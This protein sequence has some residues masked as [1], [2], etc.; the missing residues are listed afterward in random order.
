MNNVF[1]LNTNG[2]KPQNE[3]QPEA[4]VL[5]QIN[6]TATHAGDSYSVTGAFAD[7]LQYAALAM[8]KTLSELA[9]KIRD[10]GNAGHSPSPAL[11]EKLDTRRGLAPFLETTD[12][13]ELPSPR[14]MR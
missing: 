6:I 10:S 1:Q 11:H 12:F 2:S 8:I 9:D 5:G 14:K 13:A 3:D 7:R 4:K